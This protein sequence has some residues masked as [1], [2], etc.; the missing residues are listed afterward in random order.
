M[1]LIVQTGPFQ[2]LKLDSNE[3]IRTCMGFDTR[4]TEHTWYR[5]V[6]VGNVSTICQ[7]VPISEAINLEL[8]YQ[9]AVKNKTLED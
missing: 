9:E 1:K 3:Y 8:F 5:R 2:V 4:Y 6:N 7:P